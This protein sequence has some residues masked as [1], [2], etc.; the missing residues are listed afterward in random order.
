MKELRSLIQ[1]QQLK[2]A[3]F[4]EEVVEQRLSI[5]ELKRELN[6]VKVIFWYLRLELFNIHVQTFFIN[7]VI[8]LSNRNS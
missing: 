5:N 6:F 2:I 8:K 1:T 3:E 4:Q 7:I